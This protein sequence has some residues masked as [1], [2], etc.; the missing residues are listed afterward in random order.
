MIR[1]EFGKGRVKVHATFGGEPYDG[2]ETT[3]QEEC[4]HVDMSKVRTKF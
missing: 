2:K 3:E 4:R 1:K